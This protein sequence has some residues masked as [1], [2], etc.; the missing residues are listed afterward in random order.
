MP[1]VVAAGLMEELPVLVDLVAA[2][3]AAIRVLLAPLILAVAVAVAVVL[4]LQLAL[5]AQAAPA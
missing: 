2:V 4:L 5:A 3:M 1:V